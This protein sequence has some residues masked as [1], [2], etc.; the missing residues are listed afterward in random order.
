MADGMEREMA[1]KA[2]K[3]EREMGSFLKNMNTSE[4]TPAVPFKKQKGNN[5]ESRRKERKERK[6]RETKRKKV[7]G[8]CLKNRMP[9]E[10]PMECGECGREALEGRNGLELCH[11]PKCSQRK[12]CDECGRKALGRDG[13]ELCH[14]F[15]CSHAEKCPWCGQRTDTGDYA[16]VVH[17]RTCPLTKKC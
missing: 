2:N 10:Q 11:Y 16:P 1:D 7:L 17:S 4:P 8:V 6:R 12:C 13:L 3:M 15:T 5:D 9:A 14:Y